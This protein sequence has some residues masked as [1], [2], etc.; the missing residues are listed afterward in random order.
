MTI[1]ELKDKMKDD[2][3]ALKVIADLEAKINTDYLTD[4]IALKKENEK[5]NFNHELLYNQIMNG[6]GVKEESKNESPVFKDYSDEIIKEL[7]KIK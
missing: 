1:Q 7:R 5:L 2:A 6:A 3:E 4:N